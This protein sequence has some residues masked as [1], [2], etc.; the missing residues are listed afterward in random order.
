M[1]PMC[2][3]LSLAE[4]LVAGGALVGYQEIAICD[5]TNGATWGT[6]EVANL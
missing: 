3:Y 5:L 2:E 1:A 4:M 6:T